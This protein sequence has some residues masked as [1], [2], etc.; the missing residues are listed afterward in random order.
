MSRTVES[1]QPTL[2]IAKAWLPILTA[3][4]GGLWVFYQYLDKQSADQ[5][6]Q[7]DR[8]LELERQASINQ[9]KEQQSRLLEAQRPFLVKQLDLYFET[10]SVVGKLVSIDPSSSE[11]ENLERRF[12]ALY[13]SELS[14][15]EHRVVEQAM[16]RFGDALKQFKQTK[17]AEDMSK[18]QSAA[19]ELA[20]S[21]R[22][23]IEAAWGN[24][25]TG[26]GSSSR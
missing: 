23:G 12:W 11:W 2:E 20:H 21:I 14:M 8:R 13:W 16:K 24:T 10:A 5:R 17:N 7:T 9:T 6:Q 1:S 15:V 18:M 25:I 19:Y 4:I 3:V 22:S 26:T